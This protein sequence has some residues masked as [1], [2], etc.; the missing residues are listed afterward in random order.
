M[1]DTDS[2]GRSADSSFSYEDR[3]VD[4]R[5]DSTDDET[6]PPVW[7]DSDEL[8]RI[9]ANG[10]APS[11]A[12]LA[13]LE[14]AFLRQLPTMALYKSILVQ[15]AKVQKR[16]EKTQPIGLYLILFPG[17]GKD[18]TGLKELNDRV[19]G[20][21]LCSEFIRLRHEAIKTIFGSGGFEV[22]GQDY[23]TASILAIGPERLEFAK[24]LAILDEQLRAALLPLLDRAADDAK[25][26]A[27]AKKRKARLD[28]IAKTKKAVS[29]KKYRF[30]LLFGADSLAPPKAKPIETVFVLLT[31]ALKGAGIA[32]FVSKVGSFHKKSVARKLA[33]RRGVKGDDQKLDARGKSYLW[34]EF[35]QATLTAQEIRKVMTGQQSMGDGNDYFHIFVDKVWT[36]AFLYY[37]RKWIGNPDVVRDVRKKALESPPIRA[38]IKWAF[39]GQVA[40]LELWLISLNILDLVK[41]FL[42]PEFR[43]EVEPYHVRVIEAYDQLHSDPSHIDWFRVERLLT[44]DLRLTPDPYLVLGRASEYRFYSLSADY[45]GRIFFTMDVRDLGVELVLTYEQAN[46]WIQFHRS[47]GVDLMEETILA[48]DALNHRKRVTYA[49]VVEVFRDYFNKAKSRDAKALHTAIGTGSTEIETL[50]DFQQAVQVMLGG[51]EIFVAAHPDYGPHVT[52]IIRALDGMQH[53]GQPLNMRTAVTFS[54]ADK[55]PGSNG[56]K[57]REANQRAHF[58][59]M[60]LANEAPTILKNLER[61]HRRIERFIE[62][63]ERN[64][65]KA[66]R[67]P[68]YRER[69][70]KLRLMRI[71]ARAKHGHAS[72]LPTGTY[73][74]LLDALEAG[75]L[76]AATATK[77]FE[78][79][80]LDGNLVDDEA[81]EKAMAKLEEEITRD[82]G[83]D[84]FHMDPPPDIQMPKWLKKLI[85]AWAEQEE[86]EAEKR[87]RK[88]EERRKREE[89]ERR[90]S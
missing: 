63:L 62:L 20:Y 32:R 7:K 58:A 70:T 89:K 79:V 74:T 75:R 73:H 36:T 44:H 60:K 82:V 45:R 48:S 83:M 37:R 5:Y 22:V 11:A 80:D 42:L 57:Q 67:G 41:D 13:R 19:L 15:H 56:A 10:R 86:D 6:P 33:A 77:R 66:K 65:K 47:I 87:R 52:A 46:D 39:G 69:L 64:D 31:Q 53:D 55:V 85:D 68:S 72:P 38:G 9:I 49:R 84:N 81:L 61:A 16:E 90:T 35:D 28:A 54:L 88:E 71:Y 50:S 34:R 14:D 17:E 78:L 76:K 25:K 51:D 40:L 3:R 21:E 4:P 2:D 12:E 26:L 18:N 24:R 8:R 30:D 29:K 1:G 43:T 27:D 23:K 59:A